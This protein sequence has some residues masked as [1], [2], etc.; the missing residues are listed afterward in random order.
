MKPC[1]NLTLDVG[2]GNH[3]HGDVGIDILDGEDVDFAEVIVYKLVLVDEKIEQIYERLLDV[4][5]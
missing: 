2:C 1:N 5:G 4:N 3:K